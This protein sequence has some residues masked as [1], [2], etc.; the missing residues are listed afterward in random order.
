VPGTPTAQLIAAIAVDGPIAF[1]DFVEFA[2]YDPE[3]GFYA[4][5]G[6]A[7]G[8]RGDFITSVEVGPLFA[9]VI[10]RWLDAAWHDLGE[11]QDFRVAEVGA[12]VGTLVRGIVKA[13][14]ACLPALDYTLVE[15]SVHLRAHH[16]SL[17]DG[18]SWQSSAT[19]PAVDQQV[20]LANELLDNL[21][22]GIAERVAD[23]WAPVVVDAYGGQ[24]TLQATAAH[25]SLAHLAA[26][27]P[28]AAVGSRV[29]SAAEAAAWVMQSKGQCERLLVFDYGA[30]T[31]ELAQRGQAGW[32]RTYAGHQ[33]GREPLIGIGAC[34]ITHDVPVDQLPTPDL[35][36]LQA[37]WL[38]A[39]GIEDLV[40]GARATWDERADI[41]DLTAMVA[42]SALNE[43]KALRDTA[44]LGGFLA[45]EWH[46]R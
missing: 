30:P 41:G 46:R 5:S 18:I 12:G 32:L 31:A 29:P 11:P 34:D 38:V 28:D 44:G 8:R 20:I 21:A 13:A 37:D 7:G 45:L 33:S 36:L 1:E 25:D 26:L 19:L 15:R 10:A 4:T 35:M 23:G 24:L 2:L 27:A 3:H 42:R 22:F 14:P 40:A 16:D 39:N 6:R 17:P 9:A 43:S